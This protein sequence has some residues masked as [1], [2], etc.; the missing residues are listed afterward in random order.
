LFCRIVFRRIVVGAY[1][2]EWDRDY[3]KEHVQNMSI[4]ALIAS[5][6]HFQVTPR[7]SNSNNQRDFQNQVVTMNALIVTFGEIM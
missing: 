4:E 1:I 5:S 6:Y 7:S 3:N 2:L